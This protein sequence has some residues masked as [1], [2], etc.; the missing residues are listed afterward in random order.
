MSG[1]TLSALHEMP[2]RTSDEKGL[3]VHPSVCLSN[4]WIVT[5]QKKVLSRFVYTTLKTT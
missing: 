2:G 3:C 5:K 1:F 4:A